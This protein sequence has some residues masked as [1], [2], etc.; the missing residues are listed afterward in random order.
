MGESYR[1][2]SYYEARELAKSFQASGKYNLFRGQAKNW[3]VIPSIGRVANKEYPK[4]K[5]KIERFYD[6]F[7]TEESLAKYASCID[8]IFSIAQHY[9]LPTYYI[10]FTSDVDVTFFFA[11]NSKEN[12]INEDCSIVCLNEE[13]FCECVEMFK[14]IFEKENVH[15]PFILKAEVD[16][17]WRLEAQ[18]GC[19]IFTPEINIE[20]F[21][22]FDRILFPFNPAIGKLKEEDIYPI[23][24]SELE[25]L[26]DHY[27]ETERRINNQ[28]K[29]V[30][31]FNSNDI[32]FN[33]VELDDE[34]NYSLLKLK[35]IHSSWSSVEYTKWFFPLTESW[36]ELDTVKCIE[37]T[38]PKI[39]KD[40]QTESVIADELS[41]QF[42]LLKIQKSTPLSFIVFPGSVKSKK[43]SKDIANM[44]SILWNGTRNLPITIDEIVDIL[45][46]YLSEIIRNKKD[47]QKNELITI[48]MQNL[49]G[50]TSRCQVNP[51]NILRAFR[52]DIDKIIVDYLPRPIPS[53]LLLH[54]P[55]P[56]YI[57]DFKKLTDLFKTELIVS[58]AIHNTENKYP[59]IYFSPSQ[60]KILGYA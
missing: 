49:Y 11:M 13:D 20:N 9:G 50:V 44:C 29:F 48:E 53:E 21:Y 36:F 10:D 39:K 41:T 28:E 51:I 31:L 58:Q 24:K 54:I 32:T 3:K 17:L 14:Y 46:S 37:L 40:T 56:Q 16:N 55:V 59:V 5:E 52:T 25:I 38:L 23:H 47:I 8:T 2:N 34:P 7:K 43:K 1:V 4:V 35:E 26:L 45:A 12:K 42:A 27:F 30:E 19:F 33:S 57:F 22:D 15:P 6:Y 18:K 60:I